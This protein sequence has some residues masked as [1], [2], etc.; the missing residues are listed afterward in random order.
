MRMGCAPSQPF[1]WLSCP[2][3]H[4]P[5]LQY[6]PQGVKLLMLGYPAGIALGVCPPAARITRPKLLSRVLALQSCLLLPPCPAA[7]AAQLPPLLFVN[8]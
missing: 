1:P 5:L 7:T 2:L 8:H 6:E 3:K 4:H